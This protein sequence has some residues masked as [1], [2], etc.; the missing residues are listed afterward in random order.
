M[1]CW[2]R[3]ANQRRNKT[4]RGLSHNPQCKQKQSSAILKHK[5]HWYWPS[6][7]FFQIHFVCLPGQ[8]EGEDVIHQVSFQGTQVA[9]L[10]D[11]APHVPRLCPCCSSLTCDCILSLP[12]PRHL[13]LSIMTKSPPPPHSLQKW[14]MMNTECPAYGLVRSNPN[15]I[16]VEMESEF[17]G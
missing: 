11:R 7:V 9:H 2:P 15:M 14:I 17:S 5:T 16:V 4:D 10:V 3:A 13:L 8:V 1:Q 12:P 6:A